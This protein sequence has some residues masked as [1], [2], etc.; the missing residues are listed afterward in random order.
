MS[1]TMKPHLHQAA[2]PRGA[3]GVVMG[4]LMG[5]LNAPQNRATVDALDPPPGG[6]VLEVGFGPGHA[7]EML[8]RSRPLGLVAG[9]DHSELM[10]TAARRRLDR[11][12]GAAAGDLRVGEAGGIPLP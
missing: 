9:V 6:A 12:R 8:A 7:L 10:V 5:N 4:W 11:S 3:A 1:D 2:K